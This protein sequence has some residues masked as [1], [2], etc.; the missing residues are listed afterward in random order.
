M[1]SLSIIFYIISLHHTECTLHSHS[2]TILVNILLIYFITYHKFKF[3]VPY[4]SHW[5]LC[6]SLE[7]WSLTN[8]DPHTSHYLPSKTY[9]CCF[10]ILPHDNGTTNNTSTTMNATNAL[11]PVSYLAVM[12]ILWNSLSPTPF[13]VG[14]LPLRVLHPNSETVG[15]GGP[16]HK[17]KFV[18]WSMASVTKME[19]QWHLLPWEGWDWLT[20]WDKLH[21]F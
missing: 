15:S 11:M 5:L 9:H 20:F 10:C 18:W 12:T 3:C 4:L 2:K 19:W 1:V 21:N 7:K 8:S 16:S 17:G 14:S 6:H 13:S